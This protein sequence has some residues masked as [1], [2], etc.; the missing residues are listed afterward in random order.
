MTQFST[1]RTNLECYQQQRQNCTEMLFI[2]RKTHR[3]PK[4]SR[5]GEWLHQSHRGVFCLK[6]QAS[7]DISV[8]GNM[9]MI[10]FQVK[11]RAMV[12]VWSQF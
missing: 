11:D 2:V 8:D 6:N 12:T 9:S 1:P 5:V 7:K 10:T 3:C 4:C